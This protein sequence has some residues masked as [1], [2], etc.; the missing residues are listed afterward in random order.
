MNGA[1]LHLIGNHLPIVGIII[2]TLVMIVGL[3]LKKDQVK[4]TA[5]GI[6]IFSAITSLFAFF[7]GEEAEEVVEDLKGVSETLIHIHEEYAE[8]FFTLSLILGVISIVTLYLSIKAN[9]YAKYGFLFALGLSLMLI[10]IGKQ[11]GTSG[12]EIRH[13]EIRSENITVSELK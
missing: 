10:F 2:G 13:T 6:N 8:L 7:T 9:K 11:V 4:Q 12:G 1:H 5:L 3:I